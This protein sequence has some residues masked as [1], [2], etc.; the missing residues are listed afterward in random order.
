MKKYRGKCPICGNAVI[1]YEDDP[2]G[3]IKQGVISSYFHLSC[4]DKIKR[5][6]DNGKTKEA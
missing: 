2:V 3:Y 6:S 1:E 5:G 4:L